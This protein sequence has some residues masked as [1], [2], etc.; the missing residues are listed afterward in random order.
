[1]SN[2][3]KNRALAKEYYEL[4]EQIAPLEKRV[5]ALKGYF[6]TLTEKTTTDLG[7]WL[8][9]YRSRKTQKVDL[10]KLIKEHPEINL[11]DYIVETETK[12]LYINPIQKSS[13]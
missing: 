12:A 10:E 2:E 3:Q 5:K 11:D 9:E 6:D 13:I 1:M 8:V 4:K 7:T